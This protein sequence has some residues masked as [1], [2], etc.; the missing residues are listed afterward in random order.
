MNTI[1]SGGTPSD[2]PSPSPVTTQTSRS[3]RDVRDEALLKV[4]H[5]KPLAY[6]KSREKAL[7]IGSGFELL[8]GAAGGGAVIHDEARDDVALA[9]ALASL[10]PPLPQAF[11]V[12]RAVSRPTVDALARE[13][14]TRAG[15]QPGPADIE[16]VLRSGDTWTVA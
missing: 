16:A 1:F 7:R 8:P 4:E 2:S 13:Q 11:G 5:G 9:M 3:G 6:G 14:E 12:L 15:Q 10:E